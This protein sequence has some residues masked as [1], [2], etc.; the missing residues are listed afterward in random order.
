M[1]EILQRI[2]NKQLDIIISKNTNELN[3]HGCIY[4]P[5]AI[6]IG[7]LLRHNRLYKLSYRSIYLFIGIQKFCVQLILSTKRPGIV[8][9]RSIRVGCFYFSIYIS[10]PTNSA[11]RGIKSECCSFLSTRNSPN[12]SLLF[13]LVIQDETELLVYRI[14]KA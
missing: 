2:R 1:T 8:L 13:F 6:T 3:C 14:K 5:S 9:L 4:L 7:S 11:R 12:P 10:S